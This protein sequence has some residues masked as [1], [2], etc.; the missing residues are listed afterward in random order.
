MPGTN[1][2]L[3]NAPKEDG[4]NTIPESSLKYGNMDE[5]LRGVIFPSKV[6]IILERV[7]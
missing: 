3:S 7:H 1:K 5:W 4:V 6:K 2:V